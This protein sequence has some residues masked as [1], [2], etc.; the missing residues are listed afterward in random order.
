MRRLALSAF[1]LS[2]AALLAIGC[3]GEPPLS[4]PPAEIPLSPEAGF[5]D[6]PARDV[7]LKGQPIHVEATARLFYNL[8]PADESPGE[9][10]IF[11]VF[12]GFAAEVVR[13]F[14]TG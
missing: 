1:P 6:V 4:G 14:G 7:S 2:A 10:P 3:H 13:A 12:N 11:V 8:R 9:K 5:V